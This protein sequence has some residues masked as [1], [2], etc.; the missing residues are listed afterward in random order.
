MSKK[1]SQMSV[2]NVNDMNSN[3]SE[4]TQDTRVKKSSLNLMQKSK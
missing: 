2:S 4:K 1:T 3:Q